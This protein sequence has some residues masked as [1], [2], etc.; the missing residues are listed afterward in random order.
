MALTAGS[1]ES[2]TNYAF[3][4][5]EYIFSRALFP[6]INT[7]IPGMVQSYQITLR[8]LDPVSV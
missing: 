3:A 6:H 7:F 4:F 8:P 2:N 5:S 1:S